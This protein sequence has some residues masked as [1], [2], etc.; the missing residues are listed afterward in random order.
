MSAFC[1]R[2][3]VHTCTPRPPRRSEPLQIAE[4]SCLTRSPNQAWLIRSE[5]RDGQNVHLSLALQGRR[6][7]RCALRV[8]TSSG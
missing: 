3:C 2:L 7:L 1:V 5:Q 6:S 4:P 8:R